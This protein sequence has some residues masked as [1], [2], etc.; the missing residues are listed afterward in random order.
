M[1]AEPSVQAYTAETALTVQV[2][3]DMDHQAAPFFRDRLLHE[4]ARGP[5]R[6]VLDLSAVSFCDSAGLSVLL[7]AWRQAD[8]AGAVLV[9]ACVP[10]NLRRML[11]LTGVDTVL[12]VY[13]TIDEAYDELWADGTRSPRTVSDSQA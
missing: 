9:L 2:S 5:R 3:G 1:A 13:E 11:S 12:R 4:I 6:V 10:P 7:G 8:R